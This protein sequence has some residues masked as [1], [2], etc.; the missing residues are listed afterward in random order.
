MKKV[1]LKNLGMFC[2]LLSCIY[3]IGCQEA[4][5]PVAQAPAE[6]PHD[7]DHDH[8][9]PHPH[10]HGDAHEHSDVP[11]SSDASEGLIIELGDGY[12]AELIQTSTSTSTVVFILDSSL[13]LVEPIDA[14]EIMVNVTHDGEAKQY[15]LTAKRQQEDPPKQSS[16]FITEDPELFEDLGHDD[17]RAQLVVEI[18]GR[19]YRGDI[20]EGHGE[21]AH[22]DH[23]EHAESHED[24]DEGDAD[25]E[26]EDDD[27]EEGDDDHGDDH[28]EDHDDSHDED[29]DSDDDVGQQENDAK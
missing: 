4:K 28:D 25:H 21:H 20:E 9:H 19:Q 13:E 14:K 18:G 23:D 6:A 10:P 22:D 15:P 27:H 2:L 7:H 12:H 24:H 29:H 17:V 3:I 5:K 1:V 8:P 16:R 26:H 11:D